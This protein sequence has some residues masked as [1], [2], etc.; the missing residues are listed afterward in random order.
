MQTLQPE[1]GEI[2]YALLKVDGFE[3][4][5]QQAQKIHEVKY[6]EMVKDLIV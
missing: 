1:M 5:D 2:I 6:E 4:E 3:Q